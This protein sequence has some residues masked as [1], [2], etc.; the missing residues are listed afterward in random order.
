MRLGFQVEVAKATQS[1]DERLHDLFLIDDIGHDDGI[2]RRCLQH[3]RVCCR[4]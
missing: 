3:T 2:V 4:L 1:L